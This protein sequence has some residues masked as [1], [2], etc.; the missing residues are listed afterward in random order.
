MLKQKQK[1]ITKIRPHDPESRFDKSV[2][3]NIE[4]NRVQHDAMKRLAKRRR[5]HIAVEYDKA[6]SQY[7]L[8]TENYI[9]RSTDEVVRRKVG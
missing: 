2:R 1:G 7:L 9:D 8:N 5:V 3:I 4:A 6:V